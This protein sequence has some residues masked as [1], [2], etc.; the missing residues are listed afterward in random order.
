MMNLPILFAAA[1]E[2]ATVSDALPYL[3][4]FVVVVVTLVILWALC[5]S[6]GL[7]LQKVM[8]PAPVA[9]PAPARSQVVDDSV[10]PEVLV[11]IAAA[12]TAVVGKPRRIVSVQPHNPA[13]SQAGRQQIHSSHNLR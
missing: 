10:P 6:T 8:P 11:V 5:A 12:V 13:W 9:Q 7:I 3:M 1:A 4:G 2:K